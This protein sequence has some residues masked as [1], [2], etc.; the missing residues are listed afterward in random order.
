MAFEDHGSGRQL[1]RFR[2]WPRTDPVSLILIALF[3]LLAML[4][5]FDQT[6][7]VASILGA[8]ALILVYRILW[9]CSKAMASLLKAIER[10]GAE[11]AV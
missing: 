10:G 1:I 5:A 4:A 3:S 2:S 7:I 11:G 9:N 8:V 6:W